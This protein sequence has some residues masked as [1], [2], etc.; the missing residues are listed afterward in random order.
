M[1]RLKKRESSEV[2]CTIKIEPDEV[3][4]WGMT[5]ILNNIIQYYCNNLL[6]DNSS[7]LFSKNSGVNNPYSL[8]KSIKKYMEEI[9]SF[10]DKGIIWNDKNIGMVSEKNLSYVER[11]SA[12]T[13]LSK[14][15]EF[16]NAKI[17]KEDYELIMTLAHS[18]EYY[19]EAKN[20]EGLNSKVKD[21]LKIVTPMLTKLLNFLLREINSGELPDPE[22]YQADVKEMEVLIDND[23]KIVNEKG[24]YSSFKIYDKDKKNYP[25][26]ICSKGYLYLLSYDKNGDILNL[27]GKKLNWKNTMVLKEEEPKNIYKFNG[28]EMVTNMRRFA[29]DNFIKEIEKYNIYNINIIKTLILMKGYKVIR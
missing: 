23:G 14:K 29:F 3:I 25:A 4:F 11:V 16:E 13:A 15:T 18:K 12:I 7:I 6:K 22:K 28:C 26:G 8:I 2:E 19:K 20:I 17:S 21:Y 5:R 27:E 10:Y 1:R 24:V 9:Y